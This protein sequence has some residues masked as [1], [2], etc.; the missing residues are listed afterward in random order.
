MNSFLGQSLVYLIAAVVALPIARRLGSVLGYLL[1]GV[2][3]GPAVCNLVGNDTESVLHFAEF[4]VVLMLFLIG[5]ELEPARPH[6]GMS[7]TAMHPPSASTYT[8]CPRG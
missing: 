4:G 8:A 2:V 7:Q 3:I 1:A 5:L 6:T